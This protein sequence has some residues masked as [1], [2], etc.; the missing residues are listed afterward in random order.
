MRITVLC[1][2]SNRSAGPVAILLAVLADQVSKGIMEMQ[3][4]DRK[5]L[6]ALT[7]FLALLATGC[8]KE[9]EAQAEVIR[10][11]KVLTVTAGGAGP[12]LEYPGTVT[13]AQT[14]EVAAE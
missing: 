3:L 8:A 9:T 10:P 11:V 7:P 6:A 12:P 4:V 14:E 5:C 2:L 13:A 1:A